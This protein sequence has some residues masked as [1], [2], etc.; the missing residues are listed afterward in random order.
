TNNGGLSPTVVAGATAGVVGAALVVH[1]IGM[2]AA[3]RT[4]GGAPTE[5]MKEYDRKKMAKGGDK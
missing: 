2:A 4:K 1:G 5:E 3:G